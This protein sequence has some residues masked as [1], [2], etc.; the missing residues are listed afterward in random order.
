MWT[1][2]WLMALGALRRNAMRSL[3]TMLGIVIGVASV[4]A[5]VT[6]GRAAT[7]RVTKEVASLGT[8]MLIVSPGSRRG[9]MTKMHSFDMSDVRALAREVPGLTG[10]APV[11]SSNVRAVYGSTNSKTTAYGSTNDYFRVRNLRV[12]AGRDFSESELEA[13]LAVCVLGETVRRKLFGPENPL[14]EMMRLDTVSCKVIGV[15]ESKGQT[16]FG[17]DQDDVVI[18]P[19]RAVQR[20]LTGNSDI[21]TIFVTIGDEATIRR[22]KDTVR[23]VLRE[24]RRTPSQEDDDF[25]IGDTRE[26]AKS[27]SSVTEA[28]TALL[29][30]IAAVSLLVG[31]IGIM[32]IMLVSVTERTR[33]IGTRLAIGALARDVLLQ[34]L[35]ESIFLCAIG[36]AVGVAVG[37]GGSFAVARMLALPF[38][39]DVVL[40]AG[41]FAFSAVLGIAFGFLPARKAA[42]LHPIEALRHE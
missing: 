23:G 6:L 24:R 37:L 10:L 31:G 17:Q 29:A 41:A 3:L 39:I 8:N 28:L 20:R 30:A 18:M 16:S 9:S 34:F 4:I 12:L 36:G 13:G 7:V 27:V 21:G 33:E 35:V 32:N 14:G 11:A 26:I 42:R 2:T 22:A 40:I 15:L 38:A 1:E 25:Y 19:L 5:M